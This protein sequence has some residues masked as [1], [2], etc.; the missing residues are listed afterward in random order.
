MPRLSS[1]DDVAPMVVEK[2]SLILTFPTRA[3]R[4]R[5]NGRFVRL[6]C[7]RRVEGAFSDFPLSDRSGRGSAGAGSDED[8]RDESKRMRIRRSVGDREYTP[9]HVRRIQISP[10]T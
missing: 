10:A 4:A 3:K 2:L 5:A 6:R 1:A 7:S 8:T 9:T